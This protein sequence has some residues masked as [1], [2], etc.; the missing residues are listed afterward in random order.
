MTTLFKT[1]YGSWLY[2]TNTPTSDLDYKHIV[3]PY[4]D[5]LLVGKRVKNEV[6]KTNTEKNTRNSA[7]DV[8]NEYIPLQVF[9]H[10]FL[11][12]QTYALE[13]AFAVDFFEAYQVTFDA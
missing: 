2:G 1:R 6:E 11:G 8:D 7:E 3:L 12:G 10:D 13:L 9:A 5:D 4:L